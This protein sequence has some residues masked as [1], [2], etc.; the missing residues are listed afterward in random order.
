MKAYR[1]LSDQYAD[2]TFDKSDFPDGY[3]I[4]GIDL[5]RYQQEVNWDQL[6]AINGNGDTFRFRFAFIKAT[7]GILMEDMMFDDHWHKAKKHKVIRG[8]YH[9]YLPNRNPKLQATNFITSVRLGQGDLPPVVD[10][11]ETKG[12]SKSEIVKGLKEF[13]ASLE[14]HYK[15]KPIIYSNISF[16]EQYLAEDLEDYPFWVAHYYRPKL[17][18]DKN[19]NWL[20]WQHS[21]CA[22]LQGCRSPV[23]ANV[24]NGSLEDLNAILIQ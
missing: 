20:F 21:D 9:Y 11:E 2:Y 6:H 7:E 4:H 24:F 19:I 3:S 5:S 16:I 22:S 14:S 12:K 8:A 10:I 17:I 1:Y 15:V 18:I 13:L 23:D